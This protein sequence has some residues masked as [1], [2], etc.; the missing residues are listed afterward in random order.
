MTIETPDQ[1][2][3]RR[4]YSMLIMQFARMQMT[5]LKLRVDREDEGGRHAVRGSW[6]ENSGGT[7]ASST[8]M[9]GL[10]KGAAQK[11]LEDVERLRK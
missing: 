5:G 9:G 3:A 7:F 10:S 1:E 8:I 4:A 11:L 6:I 2:L